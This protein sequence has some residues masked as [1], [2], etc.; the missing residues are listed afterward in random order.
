MPPKKV[1]EPEKKPLIGRVGTSL[2]VGIVGVPNVGKSTFFNV[3]TKS[4]APAENF[5]FC[6]IDPNEN[7]Y[8]RFVVFLWVY[9][10]L[11]VGGYTLGVGVGWARF[12]NRIGLHYAEFRCPMRVSIIWWSST[13]QQGEWNRILMDCSYD[14][15]R[16]LFACEEKNNSMNIMLHL[17]LPLLGNRQSNPPFVHNY[18]NFFF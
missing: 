3:L 4:S 2:R 12:S 10:V 7:K 13:S 6:T 17:I 15:L 18:S 9:C 1:E 14:I 5:P 16:H 8:R 11:V